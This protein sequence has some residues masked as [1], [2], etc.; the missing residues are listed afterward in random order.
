MTLGLV[1]VLVIVF[2]LPSL[3]RA[4]A[5]PEPAQGTCTLTDFRFHSGTILPQLSIHYRTLGTPGAP[6]VL[7]LHGTGGSSQNMLAPGF[8]DE[9]FAANAP[10]DASRYHIILPDAIGAGASCKPSDGLRASFPHYT[11]SDMVAAQHRML[12]ECMGIRHLHM[13]LGYSMG[14]MMAWEW[15]TNYPEYMDTIVPLA[16][17]PAPMSGR[18]WMLRR[19]LVESIRQDPNWQQGNYTSQ[20]QAFRQL[21]TLYNIA[22]NGGSLSWQAKAPERHSADKLVEDALAHPFDGDAN[23][24]L[25]QWNASRDYNPLPHLHKVQ[26]A[27]LAI[28]SADDERNPPEC[29][30]MEPLSQIAGARHVLLP[31]SRH[32]KGHETVMQAALWKK[33]L[34]EFMRCLV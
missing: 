6:P 17:V 15:A 12:V 8:A 20:P 1:F 5:C 33:N 32:S 21:F 10:L 18:N 13:V 14:G 9:L 25:Y 31:A 2:F 22:T 28:N 30:L 3:A 19:L 16:A 29:G 11:Y 7:V 34:A 23:D 4:T 26:A 24:F 27:V